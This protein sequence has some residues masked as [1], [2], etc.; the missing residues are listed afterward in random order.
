MHQA[1][2]AEPLSELIAQLPP[3]LIGMKECSGAQEWARR[4]SSFGDT[5]RLTAPKFVTP[6]HKS[7]KND[8]N[9]AEGRRFES[10][11]QHQNTRKKSG[12]YARSFLRLG[13]PLSSV[14][15]FVPA[16]TCFL[17]SSG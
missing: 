13:S 10:L 15:V 5:V 7:G 9:D 6:Y 3:C 4:F 17:R 2:H 12:I 8:G 11:S 1:A 14:S 16:T